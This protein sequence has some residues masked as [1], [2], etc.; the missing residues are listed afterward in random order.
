[1]GGFMA[2]VVALI[3]G[4][5]YL[6]GG[7]VGFILTPSGGDV[8]G[9]FPV[10]TFHHVFHITLGGL[11]LVAGWLGRGR[12]YCQAAGAV[13]LVLGLLGLIAPPLIAMLLA[14]PGA[15]LL[16]DNLLHLVTGIALIY[17]GLLPRTNSLTVH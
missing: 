3:F 14:H 10:N 9:I 16:T 15:N 1:M 12:L 7:V 8:L 6:L 17:F 11:G 2:N 5:L 13:F 4:I